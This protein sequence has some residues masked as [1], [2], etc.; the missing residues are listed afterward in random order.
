MLVLAS[1]SEDLELGYGLDAGWI[2][3]QLIQ[4]AHLLLDVSYAL[5]VVEECILDCFEELLVGVELTDANVEISHCVAAFLW[6]QV[7]ATACA[8]IDLEAFAT[9]PALLLVVDR[10][11]LTEDRLVIGIYNRYLD[12]EF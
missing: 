8:Y 7:V 1:G 9:Q 6:E 5:C 12:I 10:H 3:Y 11:A 4:L 2:L